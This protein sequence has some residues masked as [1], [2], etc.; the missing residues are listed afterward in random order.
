MDL[1]SYSLMAELRAAKS[2]ARACDRTAEL[3][4][5]DCTLPGSLKELPWKNRSGDKWMYVPES[6]DGVL[7]QCNASA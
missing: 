6:V 7:Q 1:D 2:R 4:P 3:C 5:P